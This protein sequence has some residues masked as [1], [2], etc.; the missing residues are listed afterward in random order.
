M[1]ETLA[2]TNARV[3]QPGGVLEHASVLVEGGRIARIASDAAGMQDADA[4]LDARD[5]LYLVPG[6]IDTHND[7]L[8]KEVNPRPKVGLPTS[9]ALRIYEERSVASGVTT[10]FH[11][12]SF[13]NILREERSV[14]SAIDRCDAVRAYQPSA[15][16]DHQV[17][18]RCDLWNAEAVDPLLES[19]L[20]CEVPALSLNDHTPGQGQF[21]DIQGMMERWSIAHKDEPGYDAEA[22]MR[23]RLESRA[24]DTTTVPFVLGRVTAARAQKPFVIT[25]HDDDTIEKV[26]AMLEA[27]CTVAEFPVTLEAA[28]YQRERG[29]FITVGAP[30]I[31]RGGSASGNQD[32]TELA[33]EGLADII[34]AD[35]HA[36]SM[37]ASAFKLVQLGVCSLEQAIAKVTD[38]PARAFGLEDR[39]RIEPGLSADLALVAVQDD[40]P[41]VQAVIRA[42]QPVY[43]R[44]AM[45]SS[46]PA[47]SALSV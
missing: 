6:L 7:G 18:H 27:G 13:A 14:Q 46:A 33:R 25:S 15:A 24:N 38:A 1:P 23:A 17:L 26:D 39:G 10:T 22:E 36:P 29:M 9:F 44:G 21:R 40:Q 20:K 31:V 32:A 4:V 5:D 11:A 16:I 41:V 19:V 2:I 35:Y 34:C 37:L 30:N 42:G 12:V 47:P 28:R 8:E 43:Q 3:V 45:L